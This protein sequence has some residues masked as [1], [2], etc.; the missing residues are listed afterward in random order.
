MAKGGEEVQRARMANPVQQSHMEAQ[1]VTLSYDKQPFT[2]DIRESVTPP[3]EHQEHFP[4]EKSTWEV[5][6]KA[7]HILHNYQP[8]S[9]EHPDADHE[10]SHTFPT[11]S[12]KADGV[13]TVDEDSTLPT[14]DA[15]IPASTEP[16]EHH[17]SVTE[18]L[19]TT[20]VNATSGADAN[21][22]LSSSPEVPQ[23]GDLPLL[24]ED[25]TT[26]AHLDL[27]SEAQHV[28]SSTSYEVSGQPEEA[29]AGSAEEISAVTSSP[30]TEET[31][32]YSTTPL[33]PSFDHSTPE[34]HQAEEE[35]GEESVNLL[36]Y[37]ATQTSVTQSL[38]GMDTS[39][40]SELAP[41][42]GSG[43]DHTTEPSGVTVESSPPVRHDDEDS[44][45]TSQETV[46]DDPT[47]HS[48]H[49]NPA[50]T[51]TAEVFT[52]T[53]DSSVNAPVL[54]SDPVTLLTSPVYVTPSLP[55]VEVE[56]SS[57]KITTFIPESNT[58]S[59]AEP[60]VD[61]QDKLEREVL[62]ESPE[63]FFNKTQNITDS[64]PEGREQDSGEGSGESSGGS[65]ELTNPTPS[66]DHTSAGTDGEDA[67]DA[68]S[69][70][71]ITFIPESNTPS[72]AEP[73]DA[74]QDKL[75]REVLR[76]SP[77]I[78]FNKTQNITDSDPEGREQDSGEGSGESSG[79][80]AELT[81]PTLSTDHTSAGT[82]SEDATDAPHPADV[83]I[84]LIPHMT[85]TRG[86]E[87]EASSSSSTAQES[88][89]DLEYSAEPPVADG[90][91]DVSKEPEVVTE[92]PYQR[93]H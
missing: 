30:H 33:L 66:T 38:V 77:E 80:S 18:S 85:L 78:F 35:S 20:A 50:E 54:N 71:I 62:R 84:T 56:A 14:N 53:E 49:V 79:G 81:N 8:A 74:I 83:K 37:E 55:S 44:S 19:G 75:E 9:E 17:I 39:A 26:D 36:L 43:S 41:R 63:V 48:G 90:S 6:E 5:I 45:S 82:D 21:K 76:E 34:N 3:S 70:E 27:T 23:E 57:P 29:S 61:I 72:G 25:H 59:G 60:L 2:V 28:Y 64:D 52:V 1:A 46:S 24:Q 73:L 7:S 51:P 88:R 92:I 87:P 69:P 4:T 58:P 91:E 10:E 68:S 31:D 13:L 22:L 15:T 65:A 42:S 12:P 16:S 47:D 67:T 86:W 32:V 40:P 93:H 89:S 11:T